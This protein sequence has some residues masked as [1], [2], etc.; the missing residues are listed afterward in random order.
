MKKKAWD[1]ENVNEFLDLC[2]V[3][4]NQEQLNNFDQCKDHLN[5]G[6]DNAAKCF[7][8][9]V[10][11]GLLVHGEVKID[12]FCKLRLKFRKEKTQKIMGKP[13]LLPATWQIKFTPLNALKEILAKIELVEEE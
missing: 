4:L 5:I 7:V 3:S 13:T 2:G 12:G 10:I 11:F 9:S 8:H 6:T 1:L